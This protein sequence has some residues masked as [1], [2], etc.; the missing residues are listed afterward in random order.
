MKR[1]KGETQMEKVLCNI[2]YEPVCHA[3]HTEKLAVDHKLGKF[4]NEKD[5]K[6]AVGIFEEAIEK[7]KNKVGICW[8]SGHEI[9]QVYLPENQNVDYFQSVERFMITNPYVEYYLK[10]YNPSLLNGLK[11]Q[12][13]SNNEE[14]NFS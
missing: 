1:H 8:Y 6:L 7:T 5:A 9:N 14:E 2:F 10:K 3:V 4:C 13:K 12:F 11:K